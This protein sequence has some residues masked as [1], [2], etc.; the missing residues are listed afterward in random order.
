MSGG[1]RKIDVYERRKIEEGLLRGEACASIAR[2]IGR[3]PSSVTREVQANRVRMGRKEGRSPCKWRHACTER[4]LCGG[5]CAREGARRAGCDAR[6]C[7][8]LCDHYLEDCACERLGRWPWV[9]NGCPKHRYGCRMAVRWKYDARLADEASSER[10]SSSRA[11]IDMDP[12]R[13]AVVLPV[14]LDCSRRG[15]SPYEIV[16]SHPG[17]GVS[18]STLYRW[19]HEGYGGLTLLDLE[20]QAGFRP[21][22]RRAPA[23]ATPHGPER[24]HAAFLGLD[25]DAQACAVELDSV[26]GTAR[27]RAALLSAYVRYL[28]LQPFL[29]YEPKGS[30]EGVNARVAE[31]RD[32]CGRGPSRAVFAVGLA[33]NGPEFA[34]AGFIGSRLFGEGSAGCPGVALYYCD[35]GSP[36]QKGRCEKNHSELRQVVPKGRMSID[37]LDAD[38]LALVMSHV[39]STPRRSL[40]GLS[41]VAAARR[42]L[43]EPVEA[44]L[45]AYGIREVGPGELYLREDLVNRGRAERGL[46][47]VEIRPKAR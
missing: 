33:D 1:Y 22:E 24:S 14:V 2:A 45:G 8:D 19:F 3:S 26:H 5:A 4:G 41:P 28:H 9:C 13:A 36:E 20:R 15:M 16:A 42:M 18:V 11:G 39:N 34:D 38:D 27:D 44:L 30:S 46:P 43:G 23:R 40:G 7:R 31:L 25:P 29:K 10:R 37:D 35:P 12:G 47:P 32:V 21:R 17:L 6:D